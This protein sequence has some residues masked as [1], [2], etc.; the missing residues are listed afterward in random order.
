MRRLLLLFLLLAACAKPHV[1]AAPTGPAGGI[2]EVTLQVVNASRR[3]LDTPRPDILGEIGRLRSGRGAA[4]FSATDAFA[5]AAETELGKKGVRTRTDQAPDLP[6]FRITL[7]DLEIRDSAS[8]GAVAFVSARYALLGA[9]GESLWETVEKRFP[10][11]LGGP[12]LTDS[13]LARIARESVRHA[14]S[15]FPPANDIGVGTGGKQAP[16]PGP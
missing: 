14:L 4:S 2:R 16:N 5:V 15:N 13:V 8:A 10:I 11:G 3:P 6:V 1:R 12:D 9:K 7:H